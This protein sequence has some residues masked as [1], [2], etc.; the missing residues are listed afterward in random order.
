MELSLIDGRRLKE[1]DIEEERERERE[2]LK[3]SLKRIDIG[4]VETNYQ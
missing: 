1:D 2:E 4:T 3:C